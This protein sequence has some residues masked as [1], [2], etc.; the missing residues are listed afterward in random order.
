MAISIFSPDQ[1]AQ[2]VQQTIPA[3]TDATHQNAIVGSVDQT[4]AQ[5]VAHFVYKPQSGWELNANAVA[6]YD[7]TGDVS[8]GAQVLLKW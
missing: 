6:R 8:V 5:V 1:L 2:I 4:G 3:A 7:W